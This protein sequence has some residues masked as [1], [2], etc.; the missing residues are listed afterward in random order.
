MDSRLT[1]KFKRGGRRPRSHG[2]YSYLTTGTLP[3]H[4]SQILGYLTAVRMGLIRHFGPTENDLTTAQI[5]LIDRI[6]TKLGVIRCLEE[7]IRENSV[8]EGTDL[9]PCLKASYLAYN[10]SL[11]LDLQ[12]LGLDRRQEA[13]LTPYEIVEREKS[14]KEGTK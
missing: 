5:V 13:I 6:T 14:S 1:V 7:H 11:R 4:R 3:E 8:I 12:A 9:A 10:N 2:G